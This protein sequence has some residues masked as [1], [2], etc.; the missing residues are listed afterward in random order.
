[1][2]VAYTLEHDLLIALTILGIVALVLLILGR[3]SL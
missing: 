3:R 1:V 2:L